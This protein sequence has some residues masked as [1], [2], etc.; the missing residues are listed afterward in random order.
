[1]RMNYR[2]EYIIGENLFAIIT[3]NPGV[4]VFAF[5]R[6][7]HF[8]GITPEHAL[9]WGWRVTASKDG[10]PICNFPD[11]QLRCFKNEPD[12]INFRR[13]LHEKIEGFSSH[14]VL[15]PSE[16][17]SI[18]HEKTIEKQVETNL[19]YNKLF[20]EQENKGYRFEEAL[21]P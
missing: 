7:N 3:E 17:F 10:F 12:R 9:N 14:L 21:N 13:R 18:Y 4:E 8:K 19:R 15:P 1:M 16:E 6:V 20:T 5:P 11:Y 2:P